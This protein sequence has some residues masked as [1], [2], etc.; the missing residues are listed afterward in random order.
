MQET[1]L[2]GKTIN[3]MC[4]ICHG[5]AKEKGFWDEERNIGE[6]LMLIV[7][8]VGEAMEGYRKENHENFR[9]EIADTFIRLFDLCGGLGINIEEEI[10]KK[11]QYNKT[12]PYK[13]GKIC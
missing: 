8:E 4:E 3:E 5:I 13:H 6:A 11:A 12:R 2:R 7:T 9:E 10:A 1:E